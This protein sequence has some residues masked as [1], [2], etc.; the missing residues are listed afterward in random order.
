MLWLFPLREQ[1]QPNAGSVSSLFTNRRI[2]HVEAYERTRFDKPAGTRGKDIAILSLSI[3][4]EK[5]T[6]AVVLRLLQPRHSM[7]DDRESLR[8]GSCLNRRYP[9]IF[10]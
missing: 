10:R 3:L 4:I 9:T 7:V 5:V 2:M 6:L 8:R 1:M